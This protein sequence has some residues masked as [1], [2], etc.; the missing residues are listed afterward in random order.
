MVLFS[1]DRRKTP[2]HRATFNSRS[3]FFSCSTF[4]FLS[5]LFELLIKWIM[6]IWHRRNGTA[7]NS[8]GISFVPFQNKNQVCLKISI[9]IG[10]GIWL[11]LPIPSSS[12]FSVYSGD[13]NSEHLSSQYSDPHFTGPSLLMLQRNNLV[14]GMLS[15]VMNK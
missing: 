15:H 8:S 2:H 13:L 12:I 9:M 10:I 11:L 6:Q 1:S 5:Q 14:Q 7:R 3:V 4:F